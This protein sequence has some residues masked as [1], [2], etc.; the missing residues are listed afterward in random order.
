MDRNCYD[1]IWNTERGCSLWDCEELSRYDAHELLKCVKWVSVQDELPQIIE[2]RRSRFGPYRVS[3]KVWVAYVGDD[4]DILRGIAVLEDDMDGKDP[5][6]CD[7]DGY[8]Y[9]RVKY[10]MRIAKLPGEDV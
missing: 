5:F 4:G 2:T 8:K 6:F 1:C 10:W 9:D 7:M 3:E